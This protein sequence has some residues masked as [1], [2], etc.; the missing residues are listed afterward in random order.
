MVGGVFPN[1]VI[2][3]TFSGSA[4]E[5]PNNSYIKKNPLGNKNNNLSNFDKKK[6]TSPPIFVFFSP[7]VISLNFNISNK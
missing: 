3:V 6:P 2:M 1:A 4:P 5:W 7:L